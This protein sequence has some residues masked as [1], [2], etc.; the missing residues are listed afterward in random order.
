MSLAASRCGPQLEHGNRL[1]VRGEAHHRHMSRLGLGCRSGLE[2]A[3]RR[4]L[5]TSRPGLRRRLGPEPHT[6]RR[7][8]KCIR[9]PK[10]RPG[11]KCGSLGSKCKLGL[12]HMQLLKRRLGLEPRTRRLG[13]ESRPGLRR[14]AH[15]WTRQGLRCRLAP[16]RQRCRLGLMSMAWTWQ[17]EMRS[18]QGLA[19]CRKRLLSLSST[20][21]QQQA[22]LRRRGMESHSYMLLLL[23]WFL[24]VVGQTDM[25]R[26]RLELQ[27]GCIQWDM[28]RPGL[29]EQWSP[30]QQQW[31]TTR[32]EAELA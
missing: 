30:E 21:A 20:S 4:G 28:R 24:M 10:C 11:L 9:G 1:G 2:C 22:D 3:P 7:G 12:K 8:P 14:T 23:L 19:C 15:R 6:S 26:M 27:A 32:L 5:H 31:G 13:L 18:Q 17:L 29:G 25:K 16:E